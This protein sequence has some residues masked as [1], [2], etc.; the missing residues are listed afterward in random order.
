M[1]LRTLLPLSLP[2]LFLAAAC[3]SAPDADVATEQG[4][5]TNGTVCGT[6]DYGHTK[7]P[8]EFYRNFASDA[9]VA[10][11][12]Q[13]IL[14]QGRLAGTS[15]PT[16]SF[17]EVSRDE[18]LLR[19][20]REVFDG[21][22][23]VFPG[24]TAGLTAPPR[25]VVIKSDIVNAYALGPGFAEDETAPTDR[26]PWIFVVHTAIL[27]RNLTDTELRGL[28]AHELGHLI[29]R[30]FLPE[31][32][33]A[34]R[35]IYVTGKVED[36]ILGAAQDDDP[37]TAKHVE[38]MLARQSRVGGLPELGLP[39]FQALGT[40][41][42]VIDLLVKQAEAAPGAAKDQCKVAKEK[43]SE[44][45]GEQLALIPA[46]D[47]QNFTPLSPTAS[48]KEK[49]EQLS[50]GL[51]DELVR[52]TSIV[53]G[54]ELPSSLLELTAAFNGFGPTALDPSSPE[55]QQLLAKM[56][57]VEKRVDAEAN[58]APIVERMMRAQ[59]DI[60]SELAALT[61]DPKFPVDQIRIFDYEED[62]DDAS[63]RVLASI[64]DD[65]AGVGLFLLSASV[66]PEKKAE[67]LQRVA[68]HKPIAYGRFID[69][70]PATCWRYYHATQFA[71]A[72]TQCT[73]ETYSAKTP[74]K[75]SGRP[76]VLDKAPAET[77]ERGYGRKLE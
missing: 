57:D 47:E 32:R 31:I 30:T 67:C 77:V 13:K 6:I 35:A 55:H 20:V 14:A 64:G 48:Q 27:E 36:G 50:R 43:L 41:A 60:R 56:L 18:H 68:D 49:L 8:D 25:V 4:A 34:V 74:A 62:A 19:L 28:F 42:K 69:P 2:A 17:V 65:P 10:V 24:E 53:G 15:G 7:T 5:L 59:A 9:D 66:S 1:K 63:A 51:A 44:L 16:A 39:A 3:S 70:H 76:S 38:E 73:A 29:L 26:S 71:K 40:Y 75:G 23:K 72:L 22:L 46:H 11:Y 45:R 52:C 12:V 61:R 54:P 21:F 33:D 37:A 58:G